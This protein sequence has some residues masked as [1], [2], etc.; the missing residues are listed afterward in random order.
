MKGIEVWWKSSKSEVKW[1]EVRWSE[2]KCSDVKWNG[3]VGNL[4]G[5][6]SNERKRS[7]DKCSEVERSVVG[8]SAVKCSEILSNRV[9]NI[10]R[11]YIDHMKFAAYMAFSF[12]TCFH[13][14]SVPFFKIIVCMFCILLF[15]FANYVFLLLFLR[16]SLV[17]FMYS[18][19][20]VCSV[21]YILFSLCCTVYC[22]CVNVYWTTA[23]GWQTNCS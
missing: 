16:I 18:Y 4:N 20:Y 23:T 7:V 15:N 14:L 1:G 6:K 2:V 13:V 10:V 8:W 19:C 17:M 22:L 11:R 21:L 5:V 9:S 12:I 3:V